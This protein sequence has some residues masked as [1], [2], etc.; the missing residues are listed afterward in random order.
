MANPV[1]APTKY[2]D[3]VIV[4]TIAYISNHKMHGD[5]VPSMAGLCCELGITKS[6]AYDWSSQDDK[7]EFSDTLE[8]LQQVQERLLLSGGLSGDNNSTITKLMLCNH[9]YSDKTEIEQ[10]NT[11][12][13]MVKVVYE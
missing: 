2:N 12:E 5:V 7:K 11:G 1:G 13:A 10:H 6:T 4:K 8:I 3:E 9:G